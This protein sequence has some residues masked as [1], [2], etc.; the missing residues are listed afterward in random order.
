VNI[1]DETLMAFAD[2]E[3]EPTLRA[4]VEAAIGRDPSVAVRVAEFRLQREKLQQAYSSVLAERV[5]ERLLAAVEAHAAPE[6][7]GTV[8]HLEP[9]RAAAAARPP[10]KWSWPEWSAIAASVLLGILVSRFGS[11]GRNGESIDA[12]P[13]GLVAR[14]SLANAL[15]TELASNQ[16]TGGPVHVGLTFA[17]KSGALCRTFI[18]HGQRD[19]SGFACFR[20]E[21]WHVGMIIEAGPGAATAGSGG[22]LRTAASAL[23]PAL[24]RAI[25][26]RML[27]DPLDAD[28]ER[29]ARARDWRR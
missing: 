24:L 17:D 23:P 5:P 18:T 11:I 22:N 4:A 6:P 25:E 9:L 29:A 26:D 10:R 15:S 16:P 21:R 2:G 3:L 13:D 19:L 20:D 28:Q 7:S 8:V 1:T 14:Q 12:G 27:G